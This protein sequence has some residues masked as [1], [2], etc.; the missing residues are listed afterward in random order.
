MNKQTYEHLQDTMEVIDK[1]RERVGESYSR[2]TS[3]HSGYRGTNLPH[4]LHRIT[5]YLTTHSIEL[6]DEVEKVVEGDV[7]LH[8]PPN[9][10]DT[11]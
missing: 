5:T 7:S 1:T 3:P 10:P 8:M 6:Q 11:H 2:L 4:I 9:P